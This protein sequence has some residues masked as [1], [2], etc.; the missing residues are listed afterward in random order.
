[1]R[2]FFR[3]CEY[4]SSTQENP[5]HHPANPSSCTETGSRGTN[6]GREASGVELA[7]AT[8]YCAGTSYT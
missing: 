4:Y 3:A 7:V 6:P 1:M 8:I 5:I 2:F